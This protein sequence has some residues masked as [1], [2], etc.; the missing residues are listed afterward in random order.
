MRKLLVLL[1]LAGCGTGTPKT[2][3]DSPP[4]MLAKGRA[5]NATHL[6]LTYRGGNLLASG[7]Y[8]SVYW[9][10]HWLSGKGAN[11][12][13]FF[14]NFLTTMSGSARFLSVVQEYQLPQSNQRMLAGSF[15]GS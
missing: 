3:V 6:H 15:K 12:A 4:L 1:L 13:S 9:G 8:T 7:Q 14:D 10:A 5:R 11:D 2:T